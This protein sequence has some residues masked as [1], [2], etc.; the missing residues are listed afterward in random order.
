VYLPTVV[1][2][3]VAFITASRTYRAARGNRFW[4]KTADGF[5]QIPAGYRLSADLALRRHAP[6]H[7]VIFRRI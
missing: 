5:R 1:L 7:S 6:L 2:L 4:R 3:V